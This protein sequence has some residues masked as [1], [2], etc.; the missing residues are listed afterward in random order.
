MLKRD[1]EAEIKSLKQSV[2]DYRAALKS[3]AAKVDAEVRAADDRTKQALKCAEL[4]QIDA[5]KAIDAKRKALAEGNE[6]L[7]RHIFYNGLNK[8][9]ITALGIQE[10]IDPEALYKMFSQSV[11]KK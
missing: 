1:L 8:G 7:S 6:H 10:K 2:K 3:N 9:L 4:A 11:W 5:A